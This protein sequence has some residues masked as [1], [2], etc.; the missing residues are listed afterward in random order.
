M[1][2]EKLVRRV[3]ILDFRVVKDFIWVEVKEPETTV[4]VIEVEEEV[5]EEEYM[6]EDTFVM[7]EEGICGN[8]EI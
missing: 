1:A 2:D 8:G 5:K 3:V 7:Y 4:C 6:L